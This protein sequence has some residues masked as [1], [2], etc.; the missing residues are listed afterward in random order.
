MGN[1]VAVVRAALEALANLL[2]MMT[3]VAKFC[4]FLERGGLEASVRTLRSDASGHK[5]CLGI[6]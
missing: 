5:V 3:A 6:P 4:L 1:M 2:K